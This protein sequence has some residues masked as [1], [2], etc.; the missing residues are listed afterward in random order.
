MIQGENKKSIHKRRS[1][2]ILSILVAIQPGGAHHQG[3]RHAH[4]DPDAGDEHSITNAVRFMV[5]EDLEA[6]KRTQDWLK[7]NLQEA[8]DKEVWSPSSPDYSLLDNFVCG[9]SEL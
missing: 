4:E 5:L 2:R 3:P 9:V 6:S 8:W 1:D 7:E